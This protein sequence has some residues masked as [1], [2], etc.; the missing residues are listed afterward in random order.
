M[1]IAIAGLGTIGLRHLSILQ[2]TEGVEVVAAADPYVVAP[3]ELAVPTFSSYEEMVDRRSIDA[4]VLCTPSWLHSE[5]GV[6]AAERGIHV[7]SEKPLAINLEGADDVIGACSRAG[8]RLVVLHQYRYHAPLMA[9]K[10]SIDDGELGRLAFVNISFHWRRDT[11]YYEKGGGWRGTWKGDGGGA[12]MNQGA[13]AVDLAR[14]LG[15][16]IASVMACATN[17]EHSIEAEDTVCVA[18]RFVNGGLGMIQVTTCADENHPA[19]IQIQ[20]TDG[21]AVVA[22]QTIAYNGGTPVQVSSSSALTR[23]NSTRSFARLP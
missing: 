8:V 2:A 1:K 19:L 5:Q 18:V 15:G 11:A 22:G 9:L 16:P 17:I 14:W 7:I 13:H 4:V 12:L 20:G 21:T 23:R 3:E 6:M 10:R